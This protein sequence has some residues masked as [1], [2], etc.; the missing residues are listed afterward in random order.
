M[1]WILGIIEWLA[2]LWLKTPQAPPPVAQEAR[3]AGQATQ[4]QADTSAALSASQSELK[5]VVNAPSTEAGVVDELN[6]GQF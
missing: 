2:S 1:S 4:A 6:K 3:D 5:A